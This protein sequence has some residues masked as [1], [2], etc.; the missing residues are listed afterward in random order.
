MARLVVESMDG[1]TETRVLV[2]VALASGG[3]VDLLNGGQ[4]RSWAF[5]Y[6]A[7]RR[8]S[9]FFANVGLDRS[10][11]LTFT[12][13]N[14]RSVRLFLPSTPREDRMVV[15]IFYSN[16]ERLE[17]RDLVRKVVVPDMHSNTF[18]FSNRKPTVNDECSS[19]TYAAWENKLYIV[20]CGGK[21]G[22]KIIT[23]SEVV[24]SIG[25]TVT[26]EDFYDENFLMR[27]IAA[28]FGIGTHRL[29]IAGGPLNR[30]RHLSGAVNVSE[31]VSVNV[32]I[33][34][35]D[36]CD[37]VTCGAHSYCFEG[38][39]LCQSGWHQ[40]EGC[41]TGAC[42]CNRQDCDDASCE[43]CDNG[44]SGSCTSCGAPLPF[45]FQGQCYAECGAGYYADNAT[46]VCAACDASCLTCSGS[47]AEHCTSCRAIGANAFHVVGGLAVGPGT[48]TCSATC[49]STHYADAQ[50]RCHACHRSCATCSGAGI[51]LCTSCVDHTCWKHGGCPA[52]IKPL[53]QDH[54]CVSACAT[55][56]YPTASRNC[57]GCDEACQSCNGP[58]A[59]ECI[60]CVPG[61]DK[62]RNLCVLSCPAGQYEEGGECIACAPGCSLCDGSGQCHRCDPL[63]VLLEGQCYLSCPP[64][65][66]ADAVNSCLSCD[67]TCTTCAGPGKEDCLTCDAATPLMADGECVESCPAGYALEGDASLSRCGACHA[68]CAAC[69]LPRS[70][71][72]CTS[73]V[74][75]Y[76][77]LSSECVASCPMGT[78]ADEA[79]KVC[80]RCEAPCAACSGRASDCTGCATGHRLV[81][82]GCIART[83]ALV[84][85]EEALSLQEL[86][87]LVSAAR[88]QATTGLD[89]GYP[90]S[91]LTLLVP[92]LHTAANITDGALTPEIQ[93]VRIQGHGIIASAFNTTGEPIAYTCALNGTFTLTFNGETTEPI[94]IY[95]SHES[96][97]SK[98][99]ALPTVGLVE[100]E[101]T[102]SAALALQQTYD[103]LDAVMAIN[104]EIEYEVSVQLAITFTGEG[105]PRNRRALPT[106][107]MD[108]S[109]VVGL[110]TS[111]TVEH[112]ELDAER[113][114][115]PE[116]SINIS[117]SFDELSGRTESLQLSFE[118]QST[119][120]MPLN[121]S[122]TAM[123]AA[124]T[125][126]STI[127]EVEVF[128]TQAATSREWLVRFYPDGTP[129][130]R[131][132]QPEITLDGALL[133]LY[134]PP[135]SPPT[136]PSPPAAPGPLPPRPPSSPP[137]PPPQPPPSPPGPSSPSPRLPPSLPPPSPPLPSPPPPSP[138][139]PPPSPLPSPPPPSPPPSPPSP[140]TQPPEGT[141]GYVPPTECRTPT[142]GS[143]RCVCQYV[144]EA[145]C[146]LG[147]VDVVL[148]CLD[149][150]TGQRALRDVALD[151]SPFSD[152]GRRLDDPLSQF[153]TE[154]EIT[155][156]DGCCEPS[157][158]QPPD[159]SYEEVHQVAVEF[160]AAGDVS[161][162]GDVERA[163]LQSKFAEAAGVPTEDVS[164]EVLSASVNIRATVRVADQSS[165]SVLASSLTSQM[166]TTSAASSF[167]GVQV[168]TAPTAQVVTVQVFNYPSPPPP[169]PELPPSPEAGGSDGSG[170]VMILGGVA[171]VL[172]LLFALGAILLRYRRFKMRSLNKTAPGTPLGA[173]PPPVLHGLISLPSH[174]DPELT[175]ST[176]ERAEQAA[177]D[178]AFDSTNERSTDE[179]MVRIS[180]PVGASPPPSPPCEHKHRAVASKWAVGH[181]RAWA[182]VGVAV[183]GI[184]SLKVAC[185]PRSHP[186]HMAPEL[187]TLATGLSTP[188]STSRRLE[189]HSPVSRRLTAV[190]AADA[191]GLGLSSSV[192]SGSV[193]T[194]AEDQIV[195]ADQLVVNQTTEETFAPAAMVHT[196]GDGR[197]TSAETCDDGNTVNLDGCDALC[198]VEVGYVCVSTNP[199]GSGLGGTTACS[200]D[201]GD[202]RRVGN[203]ACDDGGTASGDGCSASCVVEPGWT[204]V[205]GSVRSNDTCTTLCGDG[206][207]AGS[208][209]CDDGNRVAFDG[210]SM[211]CDAIETGFAC[212]GGNA[213]APDTCTACATSCATCVSP[214]ATEC[215]SCAVNSPFR[216]NWSIGVGSCLADCTPLSSWGDDSVQPNVCSPC[217]TSCG[218]C[219]GANASECVSCN[220]GGPTPFLHDGECK[221]AC[222]AVGTFALVEN[223]L[224]RCEACDGS[225]LEC[226]G[227]SSTSCTACSGLHPFF[228][229]VPFASGSCVDSC[230]SGEYADAGST[231]RQC[232]HRCAECDGPLSSNCTVCPHGS[233]MNN[234]TCVSFCSESEYYSAEHA[235]EECHPSCAS[236]SGAGANE[237]TTCGIESVLHNGTCATTCPPRWFVG[238]Q[239]SC[240]PC[241][242]TCGMCTGPSTRDCISC[243]AP[244]Q[245]STPYWLG[246]DGIRR[247]GGQCLALCPAGFFES[248]ALGK[249]Q[250]C[251]GACA[252]CAGPGD[253]NCETCS[254]LTPYLWQQSCYSRC[255]RGTYNDAGVCKV[256]D[257]DCAECIA[258][259][260]CTACHPSSRVPHLVGG[261]CTCR[262]GFRQTPTA[263]VEID[264]CAEGTHN[265]FN[266]GSC[267]NTAGGFLCSC[268]R[269]FTGDGVSCADVDECAVVAGGAQ[270]PCD[271][272]AT[273]TNTYGGFNCTCTT[274]GYTGNGFICGDADE[275]ALNIHK[276]HANAHCSNR[277]ASYDCACK[278]G[279]EP[280]ADDCEY[281]H[282][283][284]RCDDI[285][286]C[287]LGTDYCNQERATC[288]NIPGS[289]RCRC[290][291]LYQGD[292]VIC[293]SKPP[294][295]PPAPP[296][297]PPVSPPP[298]AP[299]SPPSPPGTWSLLV[300]HRWPCEVVGDWRDGRFDCENTT[301]LQHTAAGLVPVVFPGTN[302]W[303]GWPNA[304]QVTECGPLGKMLGGHGVFGR[305]AWVERT[306]D[307]LPAHE[308]L[309]VQL[310]FYRVDSWGDG[311]A[312]IWVDGSLAWRKSFSYLERGSTRACGTMG[313]PISNEIPTRADVKVAHYSDNVTIRVT[314][315]VTRSGW[316]TGK[317]WW[318]MNDFEL[319]ST[320]P[321]PSPPTPPAAPGVWGFLA[322]ERW[323]GATGWTGQP[324]P[325][326]A[327]T[328]TSCGTIGT[329]LGGYEVF[330]PGAYVEKR[331]EGLPPHSAIR[332]Q[333]MFV[334]VDAWRNG[335][336]QL[337]V[338]GVEAWQKSF[339]YREASSTP[340]C[341]RGGHPRMR[342]RTRE[343]EPAMLSNSEP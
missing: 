190:G 165:G 244:E 109:L 306:F 105:L 314:S 85:E 64:K 46:G 35:E 257:A 117:G 268:P 110:T 319:S 273:C 203:E 171:G 239:G 164:V 260:S 302:G 285:D 112:V 120:L 20:L 14:P 250:R 334:R 178:R 278:R 275:C 28:L 47:G 25:V 299:A 103:S 326:L 173:R 29:K 52:E 224:S 134:P 280:V 7:L 304:A 44:T 48:G 22:V 234:G 256:C 253:S 63:R 67:Y 19:N 179:R 220:P 286:E 316:W 154:E 1:D 26:S 193:P 119:E 16:P 27:N 122:A 143:L 61:A 126:L 104:G 303:W 283:G 233:S 147:P 251:Y 101:R 114:L 150:T 243:L 131:G 50:R 43:T 76:L 318:G 133:G 158:A 201:C 12:A 137:S 2:P 214:A 70:A 155:S 75:G 73:C 183:V 10:Y 77:G 343:P 196:C 206:N 227:P 298:P 293:M 65:Y 168:E 161:D 142:Q 80:T 54:S 148:T 38:E 331:L 13:S 135:S 93:I 337:F 31:S 288:I 156:A 23:R 225:C 274:P 145:G 341:G 169:S 71:S 116:Q 261:Q 149:A 216:S 68:S 262:P 272:R 336:G 215:T 198:Q 151:V 211:N 66:Y 45:M 322:R 270:Y 72:N 312:Q 240:R 84:A 6:S 30:R 95:D 118:G 97:K 204:C 238:G 232:H 177:I 296:T 246:R 186:L 342:T 192:S 139:P 125:A 86:G 69:D 4:D 254:F 242:Q 162:F 202:G 241:D 320:V 5:G 90:V 81:A 102:A 100:V 128:V 200:P 255:P 83:A 289:F 33:E 184:C 252:T 235:C 226:D 210:C 208:E 315:S 307:N 174:A 3:Y 325:N 18:N 136:S 297:L 56:T 282:G 36:A 99:E 212:T 176:T 94:D 247:T 188:A 41:D 34:Q 339:N 324:D 277:E 92:A 153:T 292:G 37:L 264:E 259:G 166:S 24:L 310:T 195:A 301:R 245:A 187:A 197:L 21:P 141:C 129:S 130:H 218:T 338:D 267:T 108:S 91:T 127:G 309:R 219:S 236:C 311:E 265:C 78:L 111:P 181:Y 223:G 132:P 107:S 172:V 51:G 269:G 294:M 323:P 237:C 74:D 266:A 140:P 287:A 189:E 98:I 249:C 159:I 330:G 49:P 157:S 258:P 167:L 40:F 163:S 228:D 57:T 113:F 217:S 152:G 276:C 42:E 317:P 209:A 58:S 88:V 106:L 221:S 308:E 222:P 121:V 182:A 295:A 291:D 329:L 205:G 59:S 87:G 332:I 138:S 82:G 146:S 271:P 9:T 229:A 39:C 79:S 305:G 199:F 60:E 300:S 328:T 62:R 290:D 115:F 327:S 55:G 333:F 335:V 191:G 321:H 313:H 144:W 124:L 160:T 170:I 15:S 194:F 185:G 180:V 17:V 340:A 32:T 213:T 284:F 281:C 248:D 8:L 279:F 207:K 96:V 11:D 263:C 230:A 175:G 89:A 231:C 123:R 53:W